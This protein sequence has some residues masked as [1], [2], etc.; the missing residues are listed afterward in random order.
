M[1]V[2]KKNFFKL[3]IGLILVVFDLI[4]SYLYFSS[5]KL[6]L[7]YGGE[8]FKS[9]VSNC[10]YYAVEKCLEMKIDFTDITKFSINDSGD[11]VLVSTDTLLVN[12]IAK[13]LALDCYDFMNETIEDGFLVP[14][15]SFTGIKFLSGFGQ[16]I[17]INLSTTLSVGCKI[18]REFEQ[19]GINQTR[20]V[21]SSIISTEIIVF[22]PFVKDRYY[23]EIEVVLSDNVIVGK[24]PD[25]Y[26]NSSLLGKSSN[27]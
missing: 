13:K 3:K 14:I 27:S 4:I 20:Q 7:K 26:L 1:K 5:T 12:L 25:T 6:I 19:A 10:S 9:E 15:G 23:D 2:I 11:I 18:L 8:T 21:I 24:I 22:A 17:P 16:K